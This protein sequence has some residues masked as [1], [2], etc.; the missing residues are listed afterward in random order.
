M[1]DA[2]TTNLQPYDAR[3]NIIKFIV[4]ATPEQIADLSRS[5]DTGQTEARR[6]Y[7]LYTFSEVSKILGVSRMTLWRMVK[8]GKIDTV[9]TTGE[10]RR[11]PGPA[12]QKYITGA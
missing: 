7:K 5:A 1:T 3:L 2:V 10:N 9:Q 8:Q 4:S 12:I 11:I 6:D